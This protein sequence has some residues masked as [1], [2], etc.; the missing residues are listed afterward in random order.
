M[1]RHEDADRPYSRYSLTVSCQEGCTATPLEILAVSVSELGKI[2]EA[3]PPDYHAAWPKNRPDLLSYSAT[4]ASLV[5]RISPDT[6]SLNAPRSRLPVRVGMALDALMELL[7]S[8]IDRWDIR[9]RAESGF[10]LWSTTQSRGGSAR[11]GSIDTGPPFIDVTQEEIDRL[12][13]VFRQLRDVV[14]KIEPG[15]DE[16]TEIALQPVASEPEQQISRPAVIL[17]SQSDWPVVRGKKK[18]RLTFARYNILTALINGG[19]DGLTGDSLV[20]NSGHGGAVNVLK[21]LAKSDPDWGAVILLP[22]QPGG[23]YRILFNQTET[24]GR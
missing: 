11:L 3:M 7:D 23:R 4:V 12:K 15:R 8:W 10:D 24:D 20:Q 13:W 14:E 17:G 1:S 19:T 16:S 9:F 18:G 6:R 5:C 21:T 2:L 22:G